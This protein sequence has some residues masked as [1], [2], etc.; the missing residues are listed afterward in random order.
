MAASASAAAAAAAA[1]TVHCVREDFYIVLAKS[2]RGAC[3]P[4]THDKCKFRIVVVSST[5]RNRTVK[6]WTTRQILID[7]MTTALPNKSVVMGH[8]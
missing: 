3:Y 2:Q 5:I 7:T 1:A 6:N 4:L 8:T